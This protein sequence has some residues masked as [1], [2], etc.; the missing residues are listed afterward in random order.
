VPID[1]TVEVTSAAPKPNFAE[2]SNLRR[3]NNRNKITSSA[4]TTT[5]TTAVPQVAEGE[6]INVAE[7]EISEPTSTT[8]KA[9]GSRLRPNIRPLRPGLRLNFGGKGSSTTATTAPSTTQSSVSDSS[10]D[11]AEEK[12][13]VQETSPTPTPDTLSRLKNKSRFRVP[14]KQASL[15]PK[16]QTLTPPVTGQNRKNLLSNLLPKKKSIQTEEPP[17]E[18]TKPI[19]ENEQENDQAPELQ[20]EEDSDGQE[21]SSTTTSTTEA[22]TSSTNRLSSLLAKRRPLQRR[23]LDLSSKQSNQ[24]E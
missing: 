14:E 7:H 3:Q 19:L 10:P 9:V 23:P 4:P 5:T 13:L 2:R 24:E 17:V 20:N 6:E 21:P 16:Q 1:E 22:P 18:D 15:A 11:I 12:E 8:A